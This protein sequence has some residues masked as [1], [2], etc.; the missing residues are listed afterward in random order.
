MLVTV[1]SHHS[2]YLTEY[3]YAASFIRS[4]WATIG[5]P[6]ESARV[7]HVVFETLRTNTPALL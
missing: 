1:T 4:A 2:Y 5:C 6:S 7:S 3:F